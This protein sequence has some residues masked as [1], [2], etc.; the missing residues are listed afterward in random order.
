MESDNIHSAWHD[1]SY[2]NAAPLRWA[3]AQKQVRPALA[4]TLFL[5]LAQKSDKYGCSWYAQRTLS[6][7]TQLSERGI[8]KYLTALVEAGLI[9]IIHRSRGG[10]RSTNV[11]H[12]IGWPGRERLPSSGHP[13]AGRHVVEDAASLRRLLA[14]RHVVPLDADSG[15]AQNKDTEETIITDAEKQ[16][17]LDRCLQCLGPWATQKNRRA[18]SRQ[19]D[20]LFAM[21]RAGYDLHRHVLPAIHQVVRAGRRVPRLNSWAYFADAVAACAQAEPENDGAEARAGQGATVTGSGPGETDA[22]NTSPACD[23]DP[24]ARQD[25]LQDARPDMTR[26]LGALAQSKRF[27]PGRGEA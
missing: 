7:E 11:Y 4:R 19:D 20:S 13:V 21:L 1:S 24:R 8:R 3:E 27:G 17:V 18:L 14:T 6:E 5:F 10:L 25:A 15:A 22:T 12:L 16:A 9:R 26:F 23:R 2:I